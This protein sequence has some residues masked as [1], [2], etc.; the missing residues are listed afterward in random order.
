MRYFQ[1]RPLSLTLIVCIWIGQLAVS[2]PAPERF[3]SVYA[4][5][6]S[7]ASMTYAS[8][9]STS[10]SALLA[11][12]TDGSSAIVWQTAAVPASQ[13]NDPAT[14]VWLAG[15]GTN[16]G[17]QR[18]TLSVNGRD[19]V[20]FTTTDKASWEVSSPG[21]ARLTFR[22]VMVDRNND[23]FGFMSLVLPPRLVEPGK[24]VQLSIR[25]E[26]A[27]SSAWVMTFAYPLSD[28]LTAIA[29]PVLLREGGKA[30]QPLDLEI[31]N[32]G[33]QKSATIRVPGLPQET[34]HVPFGVTRHSVKIAPVTAAKT[35]SVD[36]TMGDI[37]K[38]VSTTLT[39]VRPWTIYLVQHAHTDIGYT[40]P[41]TEILAEHLRYIDYALDYC[42]LTDSYPDDAKFRWTCETSWAVREYLKNRPAAQIARLKKRVLEGRIEVTGMLLNWAEVADENALVHSLEPV[43][44]FRDAG[45]P[46]RTAMQDDVNGYAWCLVDYFHDLG[47]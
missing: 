45:L 44:T 9:I 35:L 16:L 36:F 24:P 6:V 30:V 33:E 12:A 7:G 2:M 20:T 32:T 41:Q 10:R 27:R 19:S 29:R 1:G 8:P 43:R 46:V 3:L 22:T 39:P 40:R 26:A 21:S 34:I 47:I 42:D 4:S 28:G 11:R 31:I 25:G 13:G 14:F 15:L 17:E 5:S 38:N 18:F 37:R 23:R